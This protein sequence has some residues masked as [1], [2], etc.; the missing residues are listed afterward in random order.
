[1][2]GPAQ[3]PKKSNPTTIT[4]AVVGGIAACCCLGGVVLLA[5]L[6]PVFRQARVAARASRR[7]SVCITNLHRIGTSISLYAADND[8]FTPPSDHWMDLIATG[9]MSEQNLHCPEAVLKDPK[10]FGYAFNDAYSHNKEVEGDVSRWLV[11][12][13]KLMGRNA[14]SKEMSL[15]K[16]GRHPSVGGRINNILMR[17]GSTHPQISQ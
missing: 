2:E 12:D 1:M 10:G 13:S 6:F 17:D 9:G 15:P 16:P 3:P 7:R 5:V 4:L 11:C 8:N 14:H